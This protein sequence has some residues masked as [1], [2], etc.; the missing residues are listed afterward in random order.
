MIHLETI[1]KVLSESQEDYL[2]QIYSLTE[3]GVSATT[4]AVAD[5]LGVAPPSV[6]VM[7]Q[8]MQ[9]IGLV[10]YEPYRG[11]Q[12]TRLGSTVALELLRHHRLL[13]SFL[14]KALG[15]GW[16]EVHAEAEKL[17]HYISESFE[18]KI[19]EWLGHPSFDPH[20]DPIPDAQLR[21]PVMQPQ[22]VLAETVPGTDGIIARVV[23]Q[24]RDE[25]NL[26]MQLNLVPG[27][28]IHVMDQS[29][30]ATRLRVAPHS[31]PA[32]QI[33]L[34]RALSKKLFLILEST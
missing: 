29:Q 17:E 11:V 1:N 3:A 33:L 13:E 14:H 9:S 21:L 6:T 26:L 2:K 12:L 23:T 32:N 10:D 19:A 16:E 34:P 20:G 25:L 8:K 30:D 28:Q 15:Y 24:D 5:R 22:S 31:K 18:T 4:Q 7:V 27:S